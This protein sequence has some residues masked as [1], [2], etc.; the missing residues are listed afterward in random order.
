MRY[1]LILGA[2]SDIAKAL[3]EKYASNGYNLYLASR[4]MSE[5]EVTK[6]YITE[7]YN[8]DVKVFKFDVLEFYNHRAFYNSL[9]PKPE[10]VITTVGYLG[11]QK[12]AQKDFL[13]AKKIIDTNYTGVVSILNIV[14]ND[15]EEKKD[16]FIIG[17]CPISEDKGK[18]NFYTYYSS[19][20]GLTSYL[21]GL[22]NRLD[23]SN[24]HVMTV[25][26][27]FVYTKMTK[28][29][30]IPQKLSSTPEKVANDIFK[31]QQHGRDVIY[32]KNIWEGITLF[33]KNIPE[34]IFKKKPTYSGI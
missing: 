12:R 18:Q 20:A 10:G 17:I 11:D 5:L 28:E 4:D 16:G 22:K 31:S 7:S 13:E 3:I 14:A 6:Q 30:E 8:V 25:K 26:P 15:F 19:K 34:N 2:N 1:V 21:S 9:N 33:I 24:V 29:I 23:P 32:T 27:G